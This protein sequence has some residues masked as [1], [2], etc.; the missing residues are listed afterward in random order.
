MW[1]SA[2]FFQNPSNRC[3]TVK[4]A[5][6]PFHVAIC[7]FFSKSVKPVSDGETRRTAFQRS[8]APQSCPKKGVPVFPRGEARCPTKVPS[9]PILTQQAQTR[10]P[11]SPAARRIRRS[12]PELSAYNYTTPHPKSQFAACINSE[13]SIFFHS[14]IPNAID[15]RGAV[16]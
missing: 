2:A 16:C 15:K 11:V 10:Y 14:G 12:V 8:E 13:K 6:P 5:E 7:R 4:P 3:Q 1:Q 9:V